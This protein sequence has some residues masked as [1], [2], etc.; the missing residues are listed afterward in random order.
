MANRSLT[1]NS[2]LS[3]PQENHDSHPSRSRQPEP[4][5]VSAMLLSI[6]TATQD[7]AILPSVTRTL[8]QGELFHRAIVGRVGRGKHVHCPEL[9]GKDDQGRALRGN[10]KHAHILPLDLDDDGHLDHILIWARMGLGGQAQRAIRSLKRTWTKG[11]IGELQ[12]SVVGSGEL[13]DLRQ[14][15]KSLA[16]GVDRLLGPPS[17]SRHWISQTPYVLP[18]F[19][20]KNGRNSLEG[21][22]CEE[23][24]SRYGATLVSLELMQF[25]N[26][27]N[28]NGPSCDK[29]STRVRQHRQY[30]R[31]RRHGGH[32]PPADSGLTIAFSVEQPICGPVCLGYG[33]HFGLGMFTNNPIASN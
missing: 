6:S 33:S 9:T 15:P 32:V 8:P 19:Q 10:H 28:E 18:R 25:K 11:G 23:L 21:Q 1:R 4:A 26:L 3:I 7:G 2:L 31:V 14:L 22:L 30:I 12:V 16:H 5:R 29:L 27:A 13:E 24:A 20:K 17:C